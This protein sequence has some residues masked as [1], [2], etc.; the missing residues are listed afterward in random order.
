MKAEKIKY[1][2]QFQSRNDTSEWIGIEGQVEKG[3]TPEEALNHAR[4]TIEGWYKEI[5]KGVQGTPVSSSVEIQVD[6]GNPIQ[7]TLEEIK[8]CETIKALETYKVFVTGNEELQAAYDKRWKEIKLTKKNGFK[9]N[10]P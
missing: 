7:S 6:R 5:N 3:E 2:K 9:V 4:L 8:G 10:L 1:T